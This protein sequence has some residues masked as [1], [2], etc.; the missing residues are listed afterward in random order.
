MSTIASRK[1]EF[2]T[3]FN[4]ASEDQ[5]KTMQEGWIDY[6]FTGAMVYI[7]LGRPDRIE[8][9][10]DGTTEDWVYMNFLWSAH[11]ST[12]GGG[13]I[14]ATQNGKQVLDA[15]KPIKVDVRNDV[16]AEPPAEIVPE[17]HV[18]FYNGKTFQMKYK[19]EQYYARP[20]VHS[21]LQG[22]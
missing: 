13:K 7:A 16:S 21:S 5:Q 1:Q 2:P 19:N 12:I 17:L 14:I 20:A 4:L 8:R 18:Y 6:G 22:I 9:A 3:V 15:S 10:A 11:S